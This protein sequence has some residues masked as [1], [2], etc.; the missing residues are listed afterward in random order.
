MRYSVRVTD[1]PEVDALALAEA[2]AHLLR[3]WT[4]G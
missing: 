3:V 4:D 2:K 1:P